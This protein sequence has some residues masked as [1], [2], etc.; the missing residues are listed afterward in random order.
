MIKTVFEKA[1]R[2]GRA[3]LLPGVIYRRMCKGHPGPAPTATRDIPIG[4]DLRRSTRM[5]DLR[6]LILLSVVSVLA[7]LAVTASA[8]AATFFSNPTPIK[9]PSGSEDFGAA[10]PYPSGIAVSGLVGPITDVDVTLHRVGH[11]WPDDMDIVLVSPSGD[12]V[13]VMSDACC[14][15]TPT[16]TCKRNRTGSQRWDR[17]RTSRWR[18]C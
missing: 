5:P 16:P 17:A 8:S 10:A 15:P 14:K 11:T 13:M 1:M 4:G 12:D 9:I 3:T 18:T 2:I 6:R 7:S